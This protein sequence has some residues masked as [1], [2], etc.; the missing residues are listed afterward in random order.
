MKPAFCRWA[1]VVVLLALSSLVFWPG[2]SGGEGQGQANAN[3]SQAPSD[4]DNAAA[5]NDNSST[6]PC[7]EDE[8]SAGVERIGVMRSADEGQ[9]WAFLGHA[10]FHAPELT[11][12]DPAPFVQDGQIVLY[13]FDI[14]GAYKYYCFTDVAGV[15]EKDIYSMTYS[16][17]A[18]AVDDGMRLS[19]D[20]S[21]GMEA[22]IVR[23]PT[24][25]VHPV[26]ESSGYVMVYVAG[27]P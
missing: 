16:G 26:G 15:I 10:C 5:D 8:Y 23:D 2:C 3:D 21:T 17:G 24:V 11:P 19:D 1:V 7:A 20:P 12:V 4:N 14:A 9:T 18:W 22:D 13:F 27:I 25:A 6:A